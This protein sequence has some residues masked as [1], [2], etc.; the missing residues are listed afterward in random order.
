M[1][2]TV[3]IDSSGVGLL[4]LTVIAGAGIAVHLGVASLILHVYTDASEATP[5]PR[6]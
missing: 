3:V 5:P 2:D 6:P 4:P 1:T